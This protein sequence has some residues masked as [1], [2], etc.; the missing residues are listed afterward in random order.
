MTSGGRSFWVSGDQECF[1]IKFDTLSATENDLITKRSLDEQMLKNTV[2]VSKRLTEHEAAVTES[3]GAVIKFKRWPEVYF[4][5][6]VRDFKWSKMQPMSG[7]VLLPI[8]TLLSE[9]FWKLE[10]L[11][12]QMQ[13]DLGLNREIKSWF[14]DNTAYFFAE[15]IDQAI[16]ETGIHPE[17]HQQNL[18]AHLRD[19]QV[20]GLHYHDLQDCF[21]DPM[22]MFLNDSREKDNI[23]TIFFNQRRLLGFPGEI[24]TSYD[25]EKLYIS[26]ADWWRRWLRVF[27]QYDRTL[28]ILGGEEPFLRCDFE[29]KISEQLRRLLTERGQPDMSPEYDLYQMISWATYR[30]QQVC[31]QKFLQQ[32]KS[33]IIE[34]ERENFFNESRVISQLRAPW[35]TPMLEAWSR[36][37][38]EL[39]IF[40]YVDAQALSDQQ[41]ILI[42]CGDEESFLYWIETE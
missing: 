34:S 27:G 20:I 39:R 3:F 37:Q 4:S 15:I 14:I 36:R 10:S 21:L 33:R 41:K 23:S 18:T 31:V 2:F 42:F 22:S 29:K 28:N 7:D 25:P 16:F 17:M 32:N 1:G 5:Y 13:I 24:M 38:K 6:L 35:S 19:G 40:N 8:S 11:Q 9:A 12:Q 26:T 30:H